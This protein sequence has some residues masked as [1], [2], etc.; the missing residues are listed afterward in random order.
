MPVDLGVVLGMPGRRREARKGAV[1]GEE[2]LEQRGLE[3][4]E[5]EQRKGEV[6]ELGARGARAHVVG[7]HV[8]REAQM[9]VRRSAESHESSEQPRAY[10]RLADELLKR[11]AFVT[12]R[13]KPLETV[14]YELDANRAR[15][16]ERP[17]G[18]E[19]PAT[20]T[21]AAATAAATTAA[22]AVAVAAADVTKAAHAALPCA[23]RIARAVT[24]IGSG[25]AAADGCFAGRDGA[26]ARAAG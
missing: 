21:A 24:A 26:L 25:D 2:L 11:V 5:E 12:E 10:H 23:P 16:G 20:A 17:A 15:T 7:L 6:I 4:R 18:V 13:M 9:M 19:A 22:A 3:A 1:V 8:V 14:T